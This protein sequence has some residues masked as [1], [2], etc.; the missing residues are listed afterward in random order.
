MPTTPTNQPITRPAPNAP[1]QLNRRAPRLLF[2]VQQPVAE[3]EPAAEQQA[4]GPAP[5]TPNR[6]PPQRMPGAPRKRARREGHAGPQQ[7]LQLQD[8]NFTLFA[9]AGDPVSITQNPAPRI[10]GAE[11]YR[12][13]R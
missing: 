12:P 6:R 9:P 5:V 13:G 11:N 8:V 10:R 3:A 2:P 7:P 1:A 4:A